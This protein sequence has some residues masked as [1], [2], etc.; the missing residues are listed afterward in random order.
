MDDLGTLRDR[1]RD[2]DSRIIQLLAERNNTAKA[3][4]GLKKEKN[5]PLRNRAVEEEVLKHYITEAENASFPKDAAERVCKAL[6]SC[7]VETQSLILRKKCEK[8]VSVIGGNGKM[9]K[10]MRSYFE[11]LG[12]NVNIV[13]VSVGKMDDV[14]DSDIV[15]ISV[16]ISSVAGVIRDADRI[17]KKDALIFDIASIKS[18]FI[19]ELRKIA[20]RRKVCSVHPMFGPSAM[21]MADRNVMVCHCGSDEAV[22]EAKEIFSNDDVT[23]LIVNVERHDELMAYSM[24]FAHAANIT[25]FTVLKNSGIPIGDLKDAGS[26][27]FLNTLGTSVPVSRE[28]ASLYREIQYLN[29]HAGN[30]WEVYEASLLEVKDA[31]LSDD[32]KEFE[33]IMERGKEYLTE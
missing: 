18:P 33:R 23:P 4:G 1:I 7:S 21:S 8:N 29:D 16:P 26:T 10:W 2:I 20:E 25:F 14:K 24:S 11:S 5:I 30:M 15:V 19:T 22:A 32:P 28:N 13:D 9:G 6:I 27:T 17:C 12:S 31:A 3:I